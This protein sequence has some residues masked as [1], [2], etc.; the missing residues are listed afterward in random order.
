MEYQQFASLPASQWS[1]QVIHQV[2]MMMARF[3]LNEDTYRDKGF[4][5]DITEDPL[6]TTAN[7]RNIKIEILKV[8]NI[9][10][11]QFYINRNGL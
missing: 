9:A 10:T 8:E 7:Q 6:Y 4:M 1:I 11:T 2:K 3:N 5:I